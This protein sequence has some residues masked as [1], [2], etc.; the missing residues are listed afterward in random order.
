MRSNTSKIGTA[1]FV[2][3]L[4]GGFLLHAESKAKPSNGD[5]AAAGSSSAA[6]AEPA[7]L[8]TYVPMPVASMA[9]AMPYSAGLNI[10]TPK[11]ELFLGYSYLQGVPKLAAGNRLVWLN[12]GSSSI[13]YN[14]N[15]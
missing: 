6:A 14:F 10:G 3:L 2:V 7:A 8:N 9:A 4:M 11:V 13:A 1:A 12:G 5:E 15:R